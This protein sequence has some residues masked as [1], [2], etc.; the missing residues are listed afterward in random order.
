MRSRSPCRGPLRPALRFLA[1][2]ALEDSSFPSVTF[3]C[4]VA[5]SGRHLDESQ[6]GRLQSVSYE[7]GGVLSSKYAGETSGKNTQKRRQPNFYFPSCQ[8]VRIGS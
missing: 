8:V 6:I 7:K 5:L 3:S 4:T 1:A 2:L